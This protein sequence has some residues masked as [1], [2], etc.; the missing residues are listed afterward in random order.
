MSF[1]VIRR[2]ISLSD[3]SKPA[4][5]VCW[6]PTREKPKR[7]L[8]S[9]QRPAITTSMKRTG[10]SVAESAAWQLSSDIQTTGT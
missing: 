8:T 2:P 3:L 4:D 9:K 10:R 1:Y 5:Y 6:L 7:G